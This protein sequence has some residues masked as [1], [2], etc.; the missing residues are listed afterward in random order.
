MCSALTSSRRRVQRAFGVVWATLGVGA[1][2]R[3]RKHIHPLYRSRRGKMR[4]ARGS[5]RRLGSGSWPEMYFGRE[6]TQKVRVGLPAQ[7]YTSLEYV[8]CFA[9]GGLRLRGG[10]RQ[11][12]FWEPWISHEGW[13]W[14]TPC[15]RQADTGFV[16]SW[17]FRRPPRSPIPDVD[18]SCPSRDATAYWASRVG[19]P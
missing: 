3:R 18:R 5:W 13:V 1:L 4:F 16:I 12:A 8:G 15:A 10:C 9:S 17:C 11:S 6:Y 2:V 19:S 14:S 7:S